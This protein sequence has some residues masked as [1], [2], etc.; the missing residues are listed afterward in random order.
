[1]TLSYSGSLL[2]SVSEKGTLIRL[3][4]VNNGERIQVFRRGIDKASIS[5][6]IISRDEKYLVCVTEGQTLYLFQISESRGYLVL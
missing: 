4:N 1:M 2:A 3:Y 6:L 5:H